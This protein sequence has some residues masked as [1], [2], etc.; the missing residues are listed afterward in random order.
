MNVPIGSLPRILSSG[1][2][3]QQWIVEITCLGVLIGSG[4]SMQ[5]AKR[6]FTVTDDIALSRFG[7]SASDDDPIVFSPNHRFLAI[8]TEHGRLDLNRPET[9]L[10]VYRT[11]DITGVLT[12][13][14]NTREP[15]PLWEIRKSTYRHGPIVTQIRWLR[16]SSG[17]AFIAKTASGNNQLLLADLRTKVIHQL[18]GDDQYVTSFDIRTQHNFVYT[19][20]T[21]QPRN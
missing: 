6:P 3:R 8:C 17:V 5:A 19:A 16:D 1:L 10:R 14:Q 7:S 15:T 13:R 9:I 20:L 2:M 21:P 12:E 18:T 4:N 11:E